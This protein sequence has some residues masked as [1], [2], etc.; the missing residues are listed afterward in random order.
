MPYQSIFLL[1]ASA[2]PLPASRQRRTSPRA[3]RGH[4][5]MAAPG[6]STGGATSRDEEGSVHK[7]LRSGGL[8]QG[9]GLDRALGISF[10]NLRY[11]GEQETSGKLQ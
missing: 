9:A 11:L 8:R 6:V 4:V 7:G 1:P 10:A 2:E 3:A 5:N